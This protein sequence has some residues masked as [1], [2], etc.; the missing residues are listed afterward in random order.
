MHTERTRIGDLT[1]LKI[2]SWRAQICGK[3]HSV[4]ETFLHRK[5]AEWAL[6]MERRIG[7][8]EPAV[9]RRSRDATR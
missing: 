8:Q 2:G 7:R 3:W 9:T 1:K 4:N 6:D 5:D